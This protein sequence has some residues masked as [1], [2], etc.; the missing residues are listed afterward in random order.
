MFWASVS[1]FPE[2][3]VLG[4]LFGPRRMIGTLIAPATAPLVV[5]PLSTCVPLV[6]IAVDSGGGSVGIS[7]PEADDTAAPVPL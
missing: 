3:N 6:A 2:R 7:V 5:E 4:V 1:P